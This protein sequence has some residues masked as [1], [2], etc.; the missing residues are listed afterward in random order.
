MIR[1]VPELSKTGRTI[2]KEAWASN[3]M[4]EAI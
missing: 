3:R 1:I 2:S 4:P